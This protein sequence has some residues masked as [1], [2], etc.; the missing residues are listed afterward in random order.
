[1]EVRNNYNRRDL[2][3]WATSVTGSI[4]KKI[5][6]SFPSYSAMTLGFVQSGH[7]WCQGL[8]GGPAAGAAPERAGGALER[9]GS[10]K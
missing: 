8:P 3:I 4:W 5:A 2:C 1:M 6:T 7:M 9:G 10:Q